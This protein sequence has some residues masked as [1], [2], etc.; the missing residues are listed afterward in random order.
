MKKH[1]EIPEGPE[2]GADAHAFEVFAFGAS[3]FVWGFSSDDA[4]GLGEESSKRVG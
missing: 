2:E 1:R 4:W 3:G